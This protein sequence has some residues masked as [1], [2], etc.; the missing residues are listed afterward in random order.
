MRSQSRNATASVLQ[1]A[2]KNR[3][4]AFT[5][6]ELL[7]VIAIIAILAAMLLPALARAKAKAQR[8]SCLNNLRQIGLSLHMYSTDT[9]YYPG[10]LAVNPFVYVWPIRTFTYMGGNHKAYSC[11]TAHRNSAWNTNDNN[12]LR[13]G[14]NPITLQTDNL[15]ITETTR[16]SYGYNDWGPYPYP[17]AAS[18]P[19]YD[20]GLGGDV[21]RAPR[22][23]YIKDTM[24]KSP[25]DMIAMGDSKPDATF[26]GNIDPTTTAEWPSNRHQKQTVLNFADGHSEN[27][28]RK[29]VIDPNNQL[30]RRRWARDNQLHSD[31]IWSIDV[32]Q[33]AKTD[34]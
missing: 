29:A 31:Y 24:V 11:P 2:K 14:I 30:W 7:V 6:I 22:S 15:L 10:C 23:V 1:P 32:T 9:G 13:T 20:Q 28:L 5:L 25:S 34:P 27:A 19:V 33:E 21:V 17:G 4:T 8:T 18:V 16:F 12:S 3:L 26:D